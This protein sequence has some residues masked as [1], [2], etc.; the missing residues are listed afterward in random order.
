[1][2]FRAIRVAQ[3]T[4]FDILDSEKENIDSTCIVEK[5]LK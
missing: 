3:L 5:V 2:L 1:M 4:N